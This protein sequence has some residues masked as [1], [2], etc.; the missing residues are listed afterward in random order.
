MRNVKKR[1]HLLTPS[2]LWR[3]MGQ[4]DELVSNIALLSMNAGNGPRQRILPDDHL[5]L[6]KCLCVVGKASEKGVK[7]T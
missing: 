7:A 5:R 1:V 2:P 6:H 4:R 3:D